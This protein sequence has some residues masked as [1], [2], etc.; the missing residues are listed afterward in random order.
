MRFC[1]P[2]KNIDASAVFEFF[3]AAFF[4]E[5]KNEGAHFKLLWTETML[6]PRWNSICSNG[7]S[8]CDVSASLGGWRVF[9]KKGYLRMAFLTAG[10]SGTPKLGCLEVCRCGFFFVFL[11]KRSRLIFGSN[12]FWQVFLRFQSFVIFWGSKLIVWRVQL[13]ASLLL[14]RMGSGCMLQ[15]EPF[16]FGSCKNL[17]NKVL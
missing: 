17:Q 3:A 15:M 5:T 16:L 9:F 13:Q 12:R 14:P 11:P 8:Q 6:W 7:E 4:S 1:F 2:K 10:D